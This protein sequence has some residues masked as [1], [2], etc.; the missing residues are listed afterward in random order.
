MVFVEKPPS[1]TTPPAREHVLNN[2]GC[3]FVPRVLA[4]MVGEKLIL[5]NSDPKLHIVHSYLQQR[6]VFNASL[7]FKGHSLEITHK[8]RKPGLLQVSCDTHAWMRGYIYVFDHP[9]FAVT[10]DHGRFAIPNI[11]PR[12]YILSAWHE[13]AGVQNKEVTVSGDGDLTVNFGFP[14]K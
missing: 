12:R 6:T 9:F 1:H 2:Q 5:R 10:D 14:G 4:M 8:V 7:P 11:P 3:R 13:K